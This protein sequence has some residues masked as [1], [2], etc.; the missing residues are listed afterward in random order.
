[1]TSLLPRK[2][3]SMIA[4]DPFE[5]LI[6]RQFANNEIVYVLDDGTIIRLDP[7]VVA[8]DEDNALRMVSGEPVVHRDFQY[9]VAISAR[10]DAVQRVRARQRVQ[11]CLAGDDARPCRNMRT[12]AVK[13]EAVDAAAGIRK[14]LRV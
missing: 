4:E 1:M 9:R 14:Q 6:E 5:T 10:I 7:L 12:P 2:R 3:R 11:R 13:L 8:Q